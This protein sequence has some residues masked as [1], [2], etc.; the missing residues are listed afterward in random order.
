M[1]KKTEFADILASIDE[2][3][4][5][6]KITR[7]NAF[8][9]WFAVN[10]FNVDEDE[11]LESAAADG[12]NDQGIDIVFADEG[13][14]EVVVLQAYCPSSVDKVTPKTKWD[15]ITASMPFIEHPEQLA[16]AGRPDIAEAIATLK[17]SYPDFRIAYG[18]ISLGKKSIEVENSIDAHKASAKGKEVSFFYHHQEDI[19]ERYDAQANAA[20]G[21]AEDTFNFS[22]PHIEDNGEYGRSWIGS[23]SATELQRLHKAHSDNLFAGNIR[24]FLGARKGGI[25]EQIIK[26]AKE[27]PG[28]FWALNNGIT[29]VADTAEVMEKT[30]ANG[31]SQL[32]L[33]RFSIVNGCQTTSSLVEAKAKSSA[34]VLARVIAANA[35][36]KIDIVQYNNSQNAV[37]IWTVRAADETQNNLRAK[38]AE[39][40]IQY[41]P[42]LEGS[43]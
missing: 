15:A 14:Q 23:V 35:K 40:S 5:R 2:L 1:T 3:A 7:N 37:K 36:I 8:A 10:F 12:G 13:A 22:G 26:T 31:G 29:I 17:K 21:I 33:R 11:A 25:N 19:L 43:R 16:K 28:A 41:A 38:F 42:K 30:E 18:L 6:G 9:A 34:K 20:S 32:K 24:L 4:S 27:Q 39:I